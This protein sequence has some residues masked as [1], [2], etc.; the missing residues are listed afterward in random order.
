MLRVRCFTDTV[1]QRAH[2]PWV[3]SSVL[4]REKTMR[5]ISAWSIS[6]LGKTIKR[7]R[8]GGTAVATLALVV[9]LAP[10]ASATDLT[11]TWEGTVSMNGQASGFRVAFSDDGY[12]LYSYKDNRG[13]TRTVELSTP[14]R[15]QYV[16]PGGGVRTVGVESIVK[17]VGG[18]SYVLHV[19]FE[20]T[21]RGYLTQSYS[22]EQHDYALTDEG[23]Q[24]HV[25]WRG[26]SYFG[27]RGGATG[28]PQQVQT[29]EG[30]LQ[31]SE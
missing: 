27:D 8:V 9:L 15:L 17:R 10:P 12:A 29:Y 30:V 26:A 19:G 4:A 5:A 24:M 3:N 7:F 20:G 1:G 23:L 31:R 11:G 18:V 13:L 21:N 28:G 14:G 6:A 25:V 22:S 16:P 2:P